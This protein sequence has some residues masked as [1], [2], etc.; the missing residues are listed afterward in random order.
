MKQASVLSVLVDGI[1][2]QSMALLT[3]WP[4][5]AVDDVDCVLH[6][7]Y[8]KSFFFNSCFFSFLL[9]FLM[10]SVQDFFFSAE[11]KRLAISMQYLISFFFK[12]QA[13]KKA[14]IA[15]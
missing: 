2:N 11:T 15:N 1:I 3:W 4:T 13:D 6:L 12:T 8:M 5:L 9:V 10:H 7:F 14:A